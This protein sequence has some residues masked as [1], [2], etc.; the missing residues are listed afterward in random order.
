MIHQRATGSAACTQHQCVR[1]R[2]CSCHN[3]NNACAASS[4]SAIG[5]FSS[6]RQQGLLGLKPFGQP[7]AAA[8]VAKQTERSTAHSTNS[9]STDAT[10]GSTS[11]A[12]CDRRQTLTAAGAAAAEKCASGGSSNNSTHHSPF[13]KPDTKHALMQLCQA[14]AQKH[15]S[16]ALANVSN[17]VNATATQPAASGAHT[18]LGHDTT[19]AAGARCEH[20]A[21]L[22]AHS[23]NSVVSVSWPPH[24]QTFE[25]R[26]GRVI[27]C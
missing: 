25:G 17:N 20:V 3:W 26:G 1:V 4:Q 18:H 5:S 24:A 8:V 6:R 11:C 22:M 15:G 2:W 9:K 14:E 12:T 21:R 13:D 23:G 7:P 27:K 16:W 10:N 19:A